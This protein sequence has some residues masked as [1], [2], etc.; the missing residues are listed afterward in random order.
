MQK[1]QKLLFLNRIKYMHKVTMER[2]LFLQLEGW[3]VGGLQTTSFSI[4]K[5]E[6]FSRELSKIKDLWFQC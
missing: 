3:I 4:W 2:I 6:I 1:K 5:I